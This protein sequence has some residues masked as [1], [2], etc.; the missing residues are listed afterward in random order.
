MSGPPRGLCCPITLEIYKR[1][2]LAQD[3]YTYE[4]AAIRRVFSLHRESGAADRR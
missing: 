3:G 1:P 2:V 4:D